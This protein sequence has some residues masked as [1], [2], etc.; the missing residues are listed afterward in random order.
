MTI[1]NKCDK[2]Y[3]GLAQLYATL[4]ESAHPNYEGMIS[5]YSKVDHDEHEIHFSNRWMERRGEEHLDTMGLCMMIFHSEY[6][7]IWKRLMEKMEGWIKE[8]DRQLET[9]KP[10]PIPE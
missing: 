8:N 5:G 2:R 1:L 7:D 3:P 4:S 6:N 9:T 10:D